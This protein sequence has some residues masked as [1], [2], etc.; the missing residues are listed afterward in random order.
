MSYLAVDSD[1]TE[2]IFDYEIIRHYGHAHS[3]SDSLLCGDD[4][5]SGRCDF[6]TM[7]N[8]LGYDFPRNGLHRISIVLPKGT[9]FKLTRQNITWDNEPI[10]LGEKS[11]VFYECIHFRRC[12]YVDHMCHLKCSSYKESDRIY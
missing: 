8:N 3:N 6:W 5:L 11:I 9:I 7:K 12:D 10:E 2:R 1:G 4:V